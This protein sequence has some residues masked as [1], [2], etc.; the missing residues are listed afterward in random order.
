[1]NARTRTARP[2]L[3][4]PLLTLTA[5]LL[6]APAAHAQTDVSAALFAAN[7]EAS[8]PGANWETYDLL[9]S[10]LGIDLKFTMLPA[11]ADGDNKLGSLAAANDLPDV[12]EIRNRSLFYKLVE[13]GQ[14]APVSSLLPLMPGRTKDRYSDRKRNA[15]VTVDGT[16]YGLQDPVTLSRQYGIMVRQDWLDKLN[17]KAPTTLDEFLVVAKALTERDPDGNGR[18][19]TYGYCGVIDFDTS[20]ILPGL[21]LGNHFQWVYA[22]YG[23]SGNWNYRSGTS[24][25][26][27]LRNPAYRQAT[28]FIRRM[29]EAKVL[30]PDWATMKR[31]DL[32]NRWQQGKC[33]MFFESVGGL[34]AGF[35]NFDANNPKGE[36]RFITPP[37]G[38]RGQKGMGTY[39]NAGT[40]LV[41]SSKALKAGKGPAIAKFLEW[42]NSG[43]GYYQL[44]FGKKGVDYT[45]KAGIPTVSTTNVNARMTNTQ[46]RWIALNGKT[47]ELKGRYGLIKAKDGRTLNAYTLLMDAHKN[48][49]IDRTGDMLVPAAP[50]QADIERY[51]SESIVQFALGQRPLNDANWTAFQNGLKGINF[52]AYEREAG[53]TLKK[54][55]FIK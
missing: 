32:R 48:G 44:G 20:G 10:K 30:D 18:K 5:D 28:D 36:L 14:L 29:A 46:M 26:A 54:A 16:M 27:N 21:G 17:L 25:A 2:L 35:A 31:S 19:D 22:A 38:P 23:V 3:T 9:R 47:N 12:F 13:Q 39:A 55:G 15:L 42:A 37:K 33:G 43:E 41:V 53:L 49:W 8:A 7:P 45:L 11:G 1:M 40:L 51:V 4:R 34:N 24:F 6:A 50:N 52:D